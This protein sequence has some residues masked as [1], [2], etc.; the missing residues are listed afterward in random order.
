MDIEVLEAAGPERDNYKLSVRGK[1][2][3]GQV[4]VL[5][6]VVVDVKEETYTRTTGS[7]GGGY[8]HATGGGGFINTGAGIGTSGDISPINIRGQTDEV[9][10]ESQT[11]REARIW[12]NWDSGHEFEE[13][14]TQGFARIG[15]EVWDIMLPSV[16]EYVLA[17]LKDTWGLDVALEWNFIRDYLE[18][19]EKSGKLIKYNATAKKTY[20]DSGGGAGVF[21]E[22]RNKYFKEKNEWKNA[23]VEHKKATNLLTK[24]YKKLVLQRRVFSVI[25]G[26]ISIS[27]LAA[28]FSEF[29]AS[30]NDGY[31]AAF[32]MFGV[33]LAFALGSVIGWKKPKTW[34][35]QIIESTN[36][37]KK[38]E[39]LDAEIE[40]VDKD[41]FLRHFYEMERALTGEVGI[42][43]DN[44]KRINM[45]ASN[46]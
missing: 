45:A 37:L 3:D 25:A 41:G 6:G 20:I 21:E 5:R 2:I 16:K 30:P 27:L 7:G 18:E 32:G 35:G 15:H 10:I 19:V 46:T 40:R 17:D 26:F 22:Y 44:F 14:V 38:G 11:V 24:N 8:I 43:V 9:N 42:M 29:N 12:V 31:G 23:I 34:M 33:S 13:S 1:F 39:S 28:G 36:L 4:I